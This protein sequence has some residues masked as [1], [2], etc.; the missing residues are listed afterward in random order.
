MDSNP[1]FLATARP[2]PP[3]MRPV[4]PAEDFLPVAGS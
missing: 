2:A 3:R 4:S 1:V